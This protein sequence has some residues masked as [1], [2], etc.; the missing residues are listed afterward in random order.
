MIDLHSHILYDI[1]D[2]PETLYESM[3]LC[4]VGVEYGIDRVAATP[5]LSDPEEIAS[6]LHRRNDRILRLRE[7][8]ARKGLQLVLYPGAEVYVDDSIFHAEHLEKAALNGSRYLLV[9]FEFQGLS[10][11]RLIRYVDTIFEMDLVPIIAHPERYAYLQQDFGLVQFLRER[12]AYFQINADSLAGLTGFEEF[13]LAYRMVRHRMADF[14]ATDAHSHLGR[15]NDLLRMIRSFPPDI[16]RETLDY[17]LYTAPSCV[18]SDKEIPAHH[19]SERRHRY[20]G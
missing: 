6:F 16:S 3:R 17:M 4:E 19:R 2:G 8:I 13:D 5:H 7:E 12:G 18:L 20:D 10:P 11:R 15:M 14:I 1:D 9:E